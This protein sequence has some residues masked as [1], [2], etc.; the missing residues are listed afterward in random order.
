MEF[1]RRTEH[2][3]RTLALLPGAWNPPTLAHAA[4]AAASL[5]HAEEAVF[6]LPRVFPHKDFDGPPAAIRMEWI[7]AM[8]RLDPAFSAAVSEGGLFLDMAREARKQG[9]SRVFIVCGADAA[10][11]IATWPYPPGSE[12]E[13]QLESEFE[14]LVAPRLQSWQPP[15][16]LAARVH[17]LPLDPKLQVVSSTQIRELIRS[18]AAWEHLVPAGLAEAIRTGYV[19]S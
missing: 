14:L 3:G 11:R 6:I 9:A 5:E 13:R 7:A 12:I 1:L 8:S 17:K 2:P 16:H 19:C 15:A 4:L 18:G 10:E